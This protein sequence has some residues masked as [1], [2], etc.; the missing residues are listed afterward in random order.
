MLRY[1]LEQSDIIECVNEGY[2][3]GYRTFVLQGGEDLSYSDKD[4]CD[5]VY[6]I[7]SLH[8]DVAVTLSIGEKERATY[9]SYYDAGADRYLL[10]HETADEEHYAKL[11]PK[12]TSL[13]YRKKC[14]YNL[15]D[16]GF[17]VG[18]GFM[19][20]SPFQ[21][22]D[23]LYQDLCFIDELKPHMVGIGPF[24]PH[25]DTPFRDE[26]RGTLKQTRI[27]IALLRLMNGHLLIPATT[28]LA[29]IHPKGRELGIL[30]GANVVMPNLSP[31]RVREL[32]A[33][34]DGKVCMGEEAAQCINCI[35][36]R[37]ADIGYEVLVDRGDYKG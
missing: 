32:Y 31:V 17:Q 10:R 9:Q 2:I 18:C 24:I 27:L 25:K 28:S 3:L 6:R 15:K 30:S 4:I 8:E 36:N 20:G 13:S 26:A 35:R 12:D 33:L 14:L 34:Y 5:I 19:V 16:I 22:P 7:K 37:I 11:H 29:T 21:N 1:R 23:T